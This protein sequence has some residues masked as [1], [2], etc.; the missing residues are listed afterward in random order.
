VLGDKIQVIVKPVIDLNNTPTPV[1]AYETPAP[2]REHLLL[3][4]PADIFPYAAGGSR[5]ADL[6][7]TIPYR[8]LTDGGPPGQTRIGN[9]G[10]L[11]RYHHRLKTHAGWQ[12]RQPEPGTWLWRSPRRRVYL[13]NNHGTH[14]LGHSPYAQAIWHTAD[15]SPPPDDRIE[16]AHW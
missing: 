10:P 4:Q 11:T 5:R 1:D 7:H 3:R 16:R 14:P 9:L 2:M 12:L 15:P 6:D 13:I 8:P